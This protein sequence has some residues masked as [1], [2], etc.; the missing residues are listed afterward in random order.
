MNEMKQTELNSLRNWKTTVV[1]V[2]GVGGA[3]AAM[4]LRTYGPNVSLVARGG[5]KKSLL[6]NGLTIRGDFTGSFTAETGAVTDDPAE[7]GVQ[8]LV[9]V[10]VKN[11]AIPK[12]AEQILPIVGDD[13]LVIPVMNGVTAYRKL[14]DALPRGIVLPGLIYIVSMA[15]PDYSIVQKGKYMTIKT[16]VRPGDEKYAARAE[17]AAAYLAASGIDCSYSEN[18][19]TDI[20]KKYIL[21]CAYNVVTA[22]W[23]CNIGEIKADPVKLSDYRRLIEE[24][25]LVAK[26]EGIQIPDDQADIEMERLKKTRGDSNSSL[27]R[28]FAAKKVG[29]ME[30]FSGDLVRMADAHGVT[31]P[32]SVAYYEAMKEIAAGF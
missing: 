32:L 30:V 6:E 13:T 29:E 8:D 3:V 21:N 22:R 14:A 17:E 16:G 2:G 20:W 26:A 27:S 1:G 4:L 23:D 24:A 25:I 10:C 28:D 18:V 11:D 19:L 5:R 12:V 15:E 7:L 9:L 31:V